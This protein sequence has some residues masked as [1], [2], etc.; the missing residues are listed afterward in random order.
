M[1]IYLG[2]WRPLLL[3]R[4]VRTMLSGLYG[5]RLVWQTLWHGRETH[6]GGHLS[7]RVTPSSHLPGETWLCWDPSK[8]GLS[9]N[10]PSDLAWLTGKAKARRR[11]V[12]WNSARLLEDDDAGQHFGLVCCPQMHG[13]SEPAGPSESVQNQAN[14]EV[15][16]LAKHTLV[17]RLFYTISHL[18]EKQ[19]CLL[20]FM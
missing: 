2:S 16:S 4:L 15:R 14:V 10:L 20:F 6:G 8:P 12:L 17:P 5:L 3:S 9:L 13:Q 7:V 11:Q 18:K 1:H 19:I